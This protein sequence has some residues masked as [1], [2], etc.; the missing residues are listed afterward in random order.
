[1]KTNEVKLR[2]RGRFKRLIRSPITLGKY[3]KIYWPIMPKWLAIKSSVQMTYH[4][5]K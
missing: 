1:M 4:T 2:R 3:L 5:V